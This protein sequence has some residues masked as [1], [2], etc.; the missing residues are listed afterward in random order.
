MTDPF[1][2]DGPACVSFSGGRTSAYMLWRVLQANTREDI[3]RW[4][5]VAF[6]NTGLEHEKTLE[7]VRECGR[8]WGVRIMWVEYRDDEAGFTLV[9]FETASRAGEPFEAV[10]RKRNY[11]PNPITRFCTVELKIRAMHKYLRTLGWYE[12]DDGWDQMVGIR[13]DERPR[14][15]KIRAR[16]ATGRSSTESVKEDMRIPLADAGITVGDVGA[17][18]SAQPF[19]LEL[20]TYGGRTLEGNCV[21]CY[22]KPRKQVRSLIAKEPAHA[23]FWIKAE[24][25]VQGSAAV[26]GDGARFRNDRESYEDMLHAIQAQPDLFGHDLDAELAAAASEPG[27]DC[28]CG[29]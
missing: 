7:F 4:L 15:A 9:D 29:D 3:E 19:N 10:I 27:I 6:A 28:F 16:A 13:A 5:V 18:W 17:F 21:L 11:L 2:I 1:K 20:A 25:M 14:V 22:L 23:T 26:T 8:R 12:G 24:R